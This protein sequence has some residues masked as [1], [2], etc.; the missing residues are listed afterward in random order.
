M[1]ILSVS[2]VQ[3]WEESA[4][5][6]FL[7]AEFVGWTLLANAGG[8]A[9]REVFLEVFVSF[10]FGRR[11]FLFSWREKRAKDTCRWYWW[12]RIQ[13]SRRW[14]GDVRRKRMCFQ[15]FGLGAPQILASS[16][17][18]FWERWV[19]VNEWRGLRLRPLCLLN[20][21]ILFCFWKTDFPSQ[22]WKK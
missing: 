18:A 17:K 1:T 3:K 21:V 2:S 22:K 20:I 8:S 5:K 16:S 4:V 19:W 15:T 6:H 13:R 11:K 14:E 7:M 10:H 9:F 12:E